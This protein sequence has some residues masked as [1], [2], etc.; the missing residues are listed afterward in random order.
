[1]QVWVYFGGI[2]DGKC[3]C[4]SWS[5]NIL[6]QFWYILWPFGILWPFWY[7]FSHFGLLHQEKS[8]SPEQE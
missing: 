7:I 3:W 8:G 1:M 5:F 4:I 2:W 6:L